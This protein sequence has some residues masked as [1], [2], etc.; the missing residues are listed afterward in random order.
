MTPAVRRRL[1]EA[2]AAYG[3]DEWR[4]GRWHCGKEEPMWHQLSEDDRAGRRVRALRYLEIY[5]A[6]PTKAKSSRSKRP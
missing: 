4:V 5:D 6:L 2:V 3:Y 1:V